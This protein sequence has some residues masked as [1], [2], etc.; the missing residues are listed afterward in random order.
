MLRATVKSGMIMP[1]GCAVCS[2]RIPHKPLIVVIDGRKVAAWIPTKE[3]AASCGLRCSH[4][5]SAHPPESG[6]HGFKGKCPKCG[7]LKNA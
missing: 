6:E 7:V 1:R 3:H 4:D 5:G 2:E